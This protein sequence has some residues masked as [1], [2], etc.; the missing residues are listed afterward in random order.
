M[1]VKKL[2][3]KNISKKV[4]AKKILDNLSAEVTSLRPAIFLGGSGVGKSTLL[5]VLNNLETLDNGEVILEGEK[6]DLSA[7]SKDHTIGMVFQ[8][9]NLF[10]H[11]SVLENVTLALINI[12]NYSKAK[13]NKLAEEVLSDLGLLD[14]KKCSV[15]SLSGGQKQRLALARLIALKPKVICL[16]EPTSALDPYLTNFVADT[17]TG[18]SKKGYIVL[19]ATHDTSL[20]E[21]LDA[22]LFLM[23]DG[24]IIEQA[25][26]KDLTK[27]ESSQIYKFLNG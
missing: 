27:K 11:L 17:I 3:L 9:F 1:G 15:S 19:I 18:L 7:V 8:H 25:S 4:G 14:Y 12:L 2:I 20:I 24:K 5:R 23:S 22:N 13:A 21:R 26:S 6:L 10:E 16:D